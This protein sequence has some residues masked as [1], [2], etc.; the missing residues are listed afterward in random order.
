MVDLRVL[1]EVPPEKKK[2]KK[3]EFRARLYPLGIESRNTTPHAINV[4][5]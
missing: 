4:L 3:G 5:V 2:K 1:L